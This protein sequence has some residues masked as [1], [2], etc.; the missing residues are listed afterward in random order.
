MDTAPYT[1]VPGDTLFGVA[2]R[3][4]MSVDALREINN[5]S[6]DALAVGQVLQVQVGSASLPTPP[7]PAA[8]PP[9]RP[10]AAPPS[11]PPPPESRGAGG[12]GSLY[13][14]QPGDSMYK[15]S[16]KFGVSVEAIMAANQLTGYNLSVG[17][18]LRIPGQGTTTPPPPAPPRPPAPSGGSSTEYVVQPGDSLYRIGQKFGVAPEAIMQANNLSS[19]ALS[20]GQRLRIPGGSGGSIPTPPAPVPPAPP[21]PPAPPTPSGGGGGTDYVVQPGDSLYRIGQQFGVA[22][23]AIM[24]ANNLSSPAL[25]VGQRLRIP[26]G[27]G[28]SIPTPPTPV[29]PAPPPPRPPSPGGQG[30]VEY[31]VQPGDSLY[32][33]GLQFGVSPEDIIR[34]NDMKTPAISVGQ[35]LLIPTNRP[36]TVT[37]PPPNPGG[38]FVPPP[39][40]T[41]ST[42]SGAAYMEA[43][44]AFRLEK[45]FDAAA[46]CNRYRL[47]VTVPTGQ[48]I[49]AQMRD[50]NANSVHMVYPN[51]VM[52]SGQSNLQPSLS[53][54]QSI[55]L[56]PAHAKAL[57]Y[58][59]TH[60]GKFDAINS[61]D[62]AIFSYGFIQFVG[63]QEH[64]AS[65]ND[66]LSSM[67]TNAGASFRR[68]F[69]QVGITCE[70]RTVT[71]LDDGGR[72]LSNDDAWLFIQKDVR[73]AGAFI[74]AGFD[75]SL[76]L[77]Q[78]RMA[79]N[80]YVQPSLKR[81]I[82]VNGMVRPLGE[83]ILT[84]GLITAVISIAVSRGVG[85]MAKILS[86]ACSRVASQQGINNPASLPRIDE[87]MV[88]QD[89]ANN[90]NND[91]RVR[92][93]AQG[94]IADGLSF[95]K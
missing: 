2:K 81:S 67:R 10:P 53:G 41:P 57:Q 54:I 73:L 4:D 62:K 26:G 75:Q 84:E 33:I 77:E 23:E 68:I 93:R 89:I 51:G 78:L 18:Q 87:R 35:R 91:K 61:Y 20:V 82:D 52:Y 86:E 48:T 25:S 64:G 34:A 94:V 56:N 5:L 31:T 79:N 80:L 60:E 59:S 21:R 22:P 44:K 24:Q 30:Y 32:R 15:I 50:N 83:F 71:A 6:S 70:G 90:P 12:L 3:F 45:S 74:Q 55:G 72:R 7:P 27:S 40:P 65:L 13:T 9:P 63:K 8:P 66:L 95:S 76:V 29:P 58:T 28:G 69:E 39:P 37:P 1:V 16:Q 38:G 88:C 36:G 43:R 11:S 14:V 19:P 85:G 92:D 17:Q 47:T 46:N 42:G 49:T